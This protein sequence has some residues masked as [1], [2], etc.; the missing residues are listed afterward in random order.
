MDHQTRAAERKRFLTRTRLLDAAMKVYVRR[1]GPRPVIDDV[2]REA[3]LS[4]AT[5]YNHFISLDEVMAA[6]GEELSNQMTADILPLFDGLKEPWQRVAVGFRLF[7]LRALLDPTWAA[8]VTRVDAWP[9]NTLVARYMVLDLRNGKANG[10]FHFERIDAVSDFLR[11]ATAH[12]IQAIMEGVDDPNQYMDASLHMALTGL[13]CSARL[14]EQA[15][16]F[17]LSYLQ[18]WAAGTTAI[19]RPKWIDKIDSEEGQRFLSY[20]PSSRTTPVSWK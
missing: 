18:T 16:M 9:H 17:S 13:D 8:Y 4:R 20:Q 3:R 7:L 14:C 5:F 10:Q 19:P 11:G 15:V 2:I 1:G 12:T 6:I